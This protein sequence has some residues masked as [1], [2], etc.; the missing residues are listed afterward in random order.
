MQKAGVDRK[1]LFW[2]PPLDLIRALHPYYSEA[3]ICVL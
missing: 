1:E 3:K 2:K